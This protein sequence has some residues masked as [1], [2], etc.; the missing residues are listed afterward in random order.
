MAQWERAIAALAEDPVWFPAAT[1][2]A[3]KHLQ[4][5]FQGLRCLLVSMGTCM[6]V[7]HIHTYIQ[8]YSHTYNKNKGILNESNQSTE[9]N[10]QILKIRTHTH[11]INY[12]LT[13]WI[14]MYKLMTFSLKVRWKPRVVSTPKTW[15]KRHRNFLQTTRKFWS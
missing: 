7:V 14:V 2:G 9:E 8:T 6:C 5:Q 3:H 13:Y 10:W 12:T 15:E 11:L 1:W 4:L